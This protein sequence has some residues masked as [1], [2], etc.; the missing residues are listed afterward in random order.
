MTAY[1]FSHEFAHVFDSM[2][3]EGLKQSEAFKYS[4]VYY[5][6]EDIK[7]NGINEIGKRNKVTAKAK[8]YRIQV[9]DNRTLDATREIVNWAITKCNDTNFTPERTTHWAILLSNSYLALQKV[10]KEDIPDIKLSITEEPSTLIQ[11][12]GELKLSQN[13]KNAFL[14]AQLVIASSMHDVYRLDQSSFKIMFGQWC[15][16][17]KPGTCTV[18]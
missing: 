16:D 5:A 18:S 4:S 9:L 11:Q 12:N 1:Q 6:Y 3:K 15:E 17:D 13:Q 7:E 14:A 10:L 8:W 2:V